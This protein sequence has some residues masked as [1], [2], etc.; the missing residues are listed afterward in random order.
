MLPSTPVMMYTYQ[1]FVPVW[2]IRL[3]IEPPV[4]DMKCRATTTEHSRVLLA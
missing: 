1:P 4:S 3:P 2:V